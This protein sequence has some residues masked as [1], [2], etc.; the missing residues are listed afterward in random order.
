M[1]YVPDFEIG[2]T[3]LEVAL[4]DLATD[5]P[6]HDTLNRLVRLLAVD[7]AADG[8]SFVFD[9]DDDFTIV[10]PHWI[11]QEQTRSLCDTAAALRGST[12]ARADA[13]SAVSGLDVAP[14]PGLDGR[15]VGMA[16]FPPG[17]LAADPINAGTRIGVLRLAGLVIERHRIRRRRLAAVARERERIAGQLHDDP[18][19]A[20]TA[21]GLRLQR[22]ERRFEDDE[23]VVGE[24]RA[25]RLLTNDATDRIRHMMFGL[26]PP[27]L[28]EDGLA[29]TLMDYLEVFVEPDGIEWSVDGP[30]RG[31]P[32]HA[33]VLGFRLARGAIHNV[34]KHAGAAR[35]DVGIDTDDRFVTI[36]V[37]DDGCGF[38]VELAAGA[39]TGHAGIPY[40]E[41]LA[42][43]A[44]G[45]YLISSTVGVGT[46]VTIRLPL[47]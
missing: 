32:P 5:V 41:D 20:M 21:V 6:Q 13:M 27:S 40:A 23:D 33:A 16:A 44:G 12:A 26:H 43:E 19:Q 42:A 1:K 31:V 30:S 37:R 35:I 29:D 45:A 3:A 7:D 24:V 11:T 9:G 4:H 34:V 39:E 2:V 18:V 15:V 25:L 17:S 28:A 8:P 10:N 47:A 22:L 36:E 38:D 46:T 14:I